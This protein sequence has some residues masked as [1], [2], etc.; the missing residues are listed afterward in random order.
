MQAMVDFRGLFMDVYI[1]WPGKVHDAR[2][3]LLT[4]PYITRECVVH[5]S[6]TGNGIYVEPR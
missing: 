6:Q 3:F 1:G 4:L 2:V 5:F